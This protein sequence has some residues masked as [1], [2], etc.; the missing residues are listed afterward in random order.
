MVNK[1][2]LSQTKRMYFPS[3]CTIAEEIRRD[4]LRGLRVI[5]WYVIERK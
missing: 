5:S 3:D 1:K 4:A 2:A